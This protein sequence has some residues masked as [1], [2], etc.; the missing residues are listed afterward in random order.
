METRTDQ[1]Q[2]K[3]KEFYR[4]EASERA[5]EDWLRRGGS[6]RV[7]ESKASHY[8]IDRKVAEALSMAGA[9]PDAHVLEIGCSFGH[10]TFLLARE[11]RS[12]TAV[13]LSPESIDLAQRRAACY[14]VTNIKFKVAAAEHLEMFPDNSFDAVF[15]FSTLR[16]CPRPGDALRETRRVVK[17]G[18][19]VVVDFP[20]KL[21][22]WF[23]PIKLLLSIRPHIH[24]HLYSPWEAQRLL[25]EAGFRSVTRHVFLL[26]SKRVPDI[27]LPIARM[28][29]R[30]LSAIQPI[31]LFS[32]IIMVKGEK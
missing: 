19:S 4:Q 3:L 25:I 30:A 18:G 8:F 7:P 26:T 32:A 14:G 16:F 24:D 6:A 13:D 15:S 28:V 23:G 2:Q 5:G 1:V 10:M 27:F 21:C 17:P 31:R 29:D 20:N 12:V 22:P 9:H 11:F